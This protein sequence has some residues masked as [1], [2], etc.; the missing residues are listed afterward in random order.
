MFLTSALKKTKANDWAN[1]K[2]EQR[3]IPEMFNKYL[4]TGCSTPVVLSPASYMEVSQE[5]RGRP[6]HF[7]NSGTVSG[8]GTV[9][10]IIGF[11][12]EKE[13]HI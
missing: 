1:G 4:F 13:K 12:G 3:Q 11:I 10:S 5:R 6:P 7:L 9:K 8:L 2:N